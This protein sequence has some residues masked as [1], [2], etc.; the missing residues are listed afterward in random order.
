MPTEHGFLRQHVPLFACLTDAQ[1]DELNHDLVPRQYVK[2]DP[3]FHQSD[4]NH[5]LYIV[6][7]G[8]VRII[9]GSPDG[10]E[11]TLNIYSKGDIIGEFAA[12]DDGPRSATARALTRCTMLECPSIVSCTICGKCPNWPS[13]SPGC[14]WT[15]CVGPPTMPRPSRATT[16]PDEL[17]HILLLYNQRYGKE[18]SRARATCWTWA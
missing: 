11:T 10:Y 13:P 9:R 4:H 15:S 1:L 3:L 14:W 18:V 7:S 5:D 2:D 8:R 6:H 12:L 17:L 16:L